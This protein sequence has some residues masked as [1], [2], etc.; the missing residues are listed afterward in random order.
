[1]DFETPAED[2][3][4]FTAGQHQSL[5]TKLASARVLLG[6][7]DLLEPVEELQFGNDGELKGETEEMAS[8]LEFGA[9]GRDLRILCSRFRSNS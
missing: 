3:T 2:R 1:M 7:R 6:S 9:A 4:E 5:A 8:M